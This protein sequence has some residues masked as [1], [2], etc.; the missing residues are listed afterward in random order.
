M[1]G[2]ETHGQKGAGGL[3]GQKG[4]MREAI[5]PQSVARMCTF[6]IYWLFGLIELDDP[7][8]KRYMT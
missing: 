3:M 7:I 1:R 2:R 6:L 8:C 5:T 4:D